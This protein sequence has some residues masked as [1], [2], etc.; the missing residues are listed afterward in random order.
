MLLHQARVGLPQAKGAEVEGSSIKVMIEP[1]TVRQPL[2][3]LSGRTVMHRDH[4]DCVGKP[5]IDPS[6]NP[7]LLSDLVQND[8]KPSR[9]GVKRNP[10]IQGRF[11]RAGEQKQG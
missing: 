1:D 11:L 4:H 6:R 10:S 5:I 2:N 9:L 7:D 3:H 8:L